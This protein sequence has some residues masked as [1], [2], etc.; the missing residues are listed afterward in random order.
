MTKLFSDE[1]KA[2]RAKRKWTQQQLADELG[3]DLMTINRWENKHQRPSKL[4]QRQ[5]DRLK[6]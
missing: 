1:I 2:I 3:V 6:R 4:A 5:V